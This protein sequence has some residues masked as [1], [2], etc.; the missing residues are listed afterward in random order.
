MFDIDHIL[1]AADFAVPIRLWMHPEVN[2]RRHADR[3]FKDLARTLSRRGHRLMH[4]RAVGLVVPTA[5]V[6][7]QQCRSEIAAH[8]VNDVRLKEVAFF[9]EASVRDLLALPRDGFE[10][11]RQRLPSELHVHVADICLMA[12]G[13]ARQALRQKGLS[14]RVVDREIAMW[15]LAPSELL[16]TEGDE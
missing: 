4:C 7:V 16:D 12:L 13:A 5:G 10:D 3:A 9:R 11:P 8:V 6:T 15:R 2:R 14:T 1:G